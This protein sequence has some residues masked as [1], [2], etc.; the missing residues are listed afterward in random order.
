MVPEF[1]DLSD[2]EVELM[3]KAPILTCIL[4]AGADGNIDNMEIEGAINAANK[5]ARRSRAKLIEF[6]RLVSEDFEDKLKVVIQSFPNDTTKRTSMIVEELSHLNSVLPKISRSFAID[7]YKSI[8]EIAQMIAQSSGGVLGI[9]KVGEEE[10]KL[11]G[12]NMIK[13][14]SAL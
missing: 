2:A 12:L 13:D 11:V 14:P 8:K 6:Y 7:F 3:L 5:N 1:D 9:N 4:I 10:A